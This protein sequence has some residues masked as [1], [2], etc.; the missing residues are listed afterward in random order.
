MQWN[1]DIDE[2][3]FLGGLSKTEVF[4]A[5]GVQIFFDGQHTHVQPASTL[6]PSGR[7]P[8]KGGVLKPK[9]TRSAKSMTKKESGYY[10]SF[11]YAASSRMIRMVS[12]SA[13]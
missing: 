12:M 6:V 8:Y 7:V 1:V 2:A 9:R 3:F 5:F 4:Q 13:A 11:C 10:P